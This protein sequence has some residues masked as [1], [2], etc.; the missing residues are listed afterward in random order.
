MRCIPIVLESNERIIIKKEIKSMEWAWEIAQNW[1]L[2]FPWALRKSWPSFPAF[3]LFSKSLSNFFF[4][5]ILILH[6]SKKKKTRI[7][8]LLS[9]HMTMCKPIG[10]AFD[11][12]FLSVFIYL[13][14]VLPIKRIIL[15]IKKY[16]FFSFVPLVRVRPTLMRSMKSLNEWHPTRGGF[17][18]RRDRHLKVGLS[19]TDHLRSK[20][21][22]RGE[23]RRLGVRSWGEK[24]GR[25]GFLDW[26]KGSFDWFYISYL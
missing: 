1:L 5:R 4:G 16:F 18:W 14:L 17:L 19:L 15:P 13:F 2:N 20:T 24:R 12:C 23:K 11:F 7:L 10:M 6:H 26:E 25:V 8:I 3:I 9:M 22:S 21:L